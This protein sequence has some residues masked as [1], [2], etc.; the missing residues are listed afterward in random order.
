MDTSDDREISFDEFAFFVLHHCKNAHEQR[1][2]TSG[3]N[4]EQHHTP[5]HSPDGKQS[6]TRKGSAAKEGGTHTPETHKSGAHESESE[7]K[8]ENTGDTREGKGTRE[9]NQQFVP[10]AGELTQFHALFAKIDKDGSGDINVREM[11]LGLRKSEELSDIL[12]LPQVRE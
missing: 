7:R 8:Q 11:I 3:K 1:D 9:G 2:N 5:S 4:N 12:G 10:T 6:S